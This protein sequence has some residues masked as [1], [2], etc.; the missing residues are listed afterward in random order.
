MK[1]SFMEK[2]QQGAA[3]PH[4]PTIIT[5][6]G[7]APYYYAGTRFRIRRNQLLTKNDYIRM[8][9]MSIPQI[10]RFISEHGYARE[11][12][13]LG[14]TCDAHDHIECALYQ[15]L[16]DAIHESHAIA[17]GPL[18]DL[19]SE[20]LRRW[21]IINIIAILHQKRKRF[22][23]EKI[24]NILIPAGDMAPGDLTRLF[25]YET[26]EEVVQGLSSWR[27]HDA[28]KDEYRNPEG[29]GFFA[30]LETHL[31]QHYY[32]DLLGFSQAGIRGGKVFRTYIQ[33]E[34]DL[35]N[36]RNMIR[37]RSSRKAGDI[38][39][40]MIS[41]GTISPQQISEV[42]AAD[43]FDRFLSLVRKLPLSKEFLEAYTTHLARESG[44]DRDDVSHRMQQFWILRKHPVHELETLITTI[45]LEKMEE[46]S[47][48]HPFTILPLLVYIERKKYEVFNIRAIVRGKLDDL[49]SDL[50]RRYIVI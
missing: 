24:R 37:L 8:L 1:F 39:T 12:H 3:Q 17:P 35:L 31:Y 6:P 10:V 45:R 34:I 4:H 25:A 7:P 30:R 50:I 20:F 22:S 32:N 36:L 15:H 21:D 40:Q 46:I 44:A 43:D 5:V 2:L 18:H 47:R 33:L 41:G 28:L 48:R 29:P 26:E 14:M 11:F 16:S 23:L 19:V 9:N 13:V 49:P 38:A 27:Y 42:F